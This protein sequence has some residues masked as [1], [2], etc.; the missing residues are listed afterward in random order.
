MYSNNLEDISLEGKSFVNAL[1]CTLTWGYREPTS[2]IHPRLAV[3][4]PSEFLEQSGWPI[5]LPKT[6]ET[7]GI[8]A[9]DKDADDNP[10]GLQFADLLSVLD[11]PLFFLSGIGSFEARARIS[12]SVRT[13]LP[14]RRPYFRPHLHQ[15]CLL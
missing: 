15:Y 6:V 3:S 7:V 5:R 1:I 12:L 9:A 11:L 14:R 10:T 13:R 2:V 8:P 4:F